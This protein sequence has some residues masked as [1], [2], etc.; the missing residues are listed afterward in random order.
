MTLP[1]PTRPV[2]LGVGALAALAALS[3]T[4]EDALARVGGGQSFSTGNRGGGGGGGDIGG[5][6]A[7]ELIWLLI[8]LVIA[9]PEVGVP[10]LLVVVGVIAW[11]ARNQDAPHLHIGRERARDDGPPRPRRAAARQDA[12]APLREA[13]PA[14]SRPVLEDWVQLVHARAWAAA[15][16]EEANWEALA[17]F[18]SAGARKSIDQNVPEGTEVDEIVLAGAA[19]STVTVNFGRHLARVRLTSSRRERRSGQDLRYFVEETWTLSRAAGAVSLEP[20]AARRLGC[21]SCGAAVACDTMGRCTNCGTPITEGQL[22]WQVVEVRVHTRRPLPAPELGGGSLEEPG[23]GAPTVTAPDLA[24]QLRAFTGRHPDFKG[25][26][27]EARVRHTFLALQAAWSAGRWA[28]ARPYTTDAVFNTFRFWI[29]RYAHAGL[30]NRIEDVEVEA[31]QVVRVELDAWYEAVTVRLWA[32]GRD[33]VEDGAGKVVSGNARQPRR[34]S[35]YWTFLRAVGTG[36]ASGDPA[37][38]PSCGAP[39]DQ[40]N[41]A[42]VCGYCD[43]VITTGR[44]DWVLTRIEQPEVY[45]G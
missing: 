8:R 15:R 16:G 32:H 7:G 35:E 42:G 19:W 45:T 26:D 12:F 3:L 11:N 43:S 40:V 21:P 1:A 28:D 23:Y 18:V 22:Q 44:F 37:R 31:L 39:L 34:F 30:R 9:W 5:E 17:P 14:F 29:D 10:L 33:W 13:D 38:C 36:A 27:W 6:I 41:A 25:P 4:T 20:E 2:A 24:A